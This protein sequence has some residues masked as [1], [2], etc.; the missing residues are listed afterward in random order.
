MRT[1][2][3]T[4][5]QELKDQFGTTQPIIKFLNKVFQ[6]YLCS[7]E[8]CGQEINDRKDDLFIFGQINEFLTHLSDD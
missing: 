3:K 5:S 2:K 8:F 7:D 6:G 4:P 1:Q